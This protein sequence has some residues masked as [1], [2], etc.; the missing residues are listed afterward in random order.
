MMF[1]STLGMSAAHVSHVE[2][3][4]NFVNNVLMC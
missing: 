3:L 1:V 2:R 4:P